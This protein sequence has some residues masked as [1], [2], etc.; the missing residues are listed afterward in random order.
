MENGL[1]KNSGIKQVKLGAILSYISIAINIL[2]GLI[3]TPWMVR[4]IGQSQYGLYTLAN[5]LITL[6]LVDFG[7]SAATAR[8]VSKYHAEGNEQKV[9]DFLGVIYKLYLIIDAVIFIAIIVFYFLIESVYVNLTPEEISQ[10]KVVYLI[11]GGFSVINFPFVTLN[12][13]LTAYEKFFHEK[14]ADIIYRV[15]LVGIM[16]VV[17]LLGYGLYALVTVNAVVGLVAIVYKLI[18]IKV[19]LPLKVNFRYKSKALYK[20]IFGFSVWVTVATLAQRLVFNITPSILGVVANSAAIAVF[21]IITTIEGYSYIITTAINGMFMPNISKIY[22]EEEPEKK[23]FPLMLG[24]GKFQ[25]AVNG[26]LVAGFAVLGKHFIALWMGDGFEEAYLGILLVLIP[27]LFYNPLQIANTAMI[28][29][30]KV[31]LQAIINVIMGATNVVLCFVFAYFFGVIGACVSIF[32]AY[33]V[34]AV[35]LLFVYQKVMK[36]DIKSFAVKCYLR[37]FIPL[38]ITIGSG[39]IVNLLLADKGWLVFAVKGVIITACYLL[40]TF[41]IGL[42]KNEKRLICD[43]FFKI[44]KRKNKSAEEDA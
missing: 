36:F 22:T 6:F 20:E 23:I 14:L 12:G 43:R 15:L 19:S 25:F 8:Y 4:M 3:Y 34:R 32:I 17:L 41:F 24:V 26:L 2:A 33:M 37:L 9:N 13:I 28:V 38:T 21:G 40:F 39:V 10:F 18:V 7:L 5:S 35:S 42:N 11:A 30:K 1:L 44:F 16:I 27:G 31:K 29:T